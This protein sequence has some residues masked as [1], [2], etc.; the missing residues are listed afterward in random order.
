[1]IDKINVCG[2]VKIEL[3][4]KHGHIKTIV[5]KS[6]LV[7]DTGLN[8]LAERLGGSGQNPVS[9]M[10]IGT[11]DT[12]P[13]SGD[14]TLETELARSAFGTNSAT[15][16]TANYSASFDAGVGTG[17]IA[18]AGIFNAASSGSMFSRVT[19]TPIDKTATDSL[20]I[21]WAITFAEA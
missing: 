13:V 17:L 15:A 12:S 14:A 8:I 7:V 10:A 5:N 3:Y 11:G 9:H 2:N 19:F 16:E 18:E 4:D 20:V 21:Y 6:N 1:M